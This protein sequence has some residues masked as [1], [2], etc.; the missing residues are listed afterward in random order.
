MAQVSLYVDDAKLAELREEATE[1]GISLSRYVGQI[2]DER[3]ASTKWP[4]GFFELYGSVTDETFVEPD[5]VS[6]E[7]SL[8]DACDWFVGV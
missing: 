8:D 1:R 6:I 7:A 3:R 2:I 5:D 4:P